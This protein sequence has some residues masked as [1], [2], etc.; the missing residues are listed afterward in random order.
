MAKF[1]F[2]GM[3]N[4]GSAMLKGALKTFNKED[5]IFSEKCGTKDIMG[6]RQVADNVEC[7]KEA[8]YIVLAVKPQFYHEV[9]TEIKDYITS[10]QIIISIAPGK[11]I[12][13]IKGY[14]TKTDKIVRA[15]PNTPA[16]VLEGMTGVTYD[17]SVF[18]DKEL[19]DVKAFFES[20]G[21]MV[22]VPEKLMSTVVCASGSSPAYVYMFI[23]AMADSVVKYGMPRKDAY[24]MVA[25]TVLGAAKMVLETGEHPGVLKDN[26]CSPGGTTIA[27][28]AALEECG[29]RNAIIKATDKC[30]D[31]CENI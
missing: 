17:A 16:L 21:K 19:E 31:K 3:G 13:Y 1:G 5:M 8:K 14:I 15:M 24:E 29:F 2:I 23:E 4:M 25:Q 26:V 28:V 9:L 20:F 22:I 10:E 12:D 6:V 18:T 11:T 7:V 30:Y 27:G